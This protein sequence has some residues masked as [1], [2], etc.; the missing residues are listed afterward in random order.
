LRGRAGMARQAEETRVAGTRLTNPDRVLYPEQGITKRELAEYYAAVA[1][2][3]LPHLAGRPLTLVRC[4]AGQQKHCFVQRRAD[5]S[6]PDAV[7]RVEVPEDGGTATYMMVES[8]PGLVALVQLGVLELHT[9][10][11][12]RDRLERPDRLIFDLDPGP[13]AA[14]QQGVEAALAVRN[15]LAALGLRSFVK[16][17]GGKGLHVVLPLLRR[18]SWEEA[19]TFSHALAERMAQEEPERYLARS[20]KSERTDR[21][22]LDYLRNAWSASAVAAYSTRAREGAPVS[23]PL[24][25]EELS[26]DLRPDAFTVRSV[27]ERLRALRADPWEEYGKI[28]QSLTRKAR[29][30]LGV[31]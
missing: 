2:W 19:R 25:W 6:F 14:W 15:R 31:G 5:E 30:A 22:Y 13:D 3:I 21:V 11:S 7:R 24:R 4:P 17:T 29:A 10:G 18:H 28:R 12:R 26:A 8:L 27:P 1:E 23:V 20:A 16:T 9:W